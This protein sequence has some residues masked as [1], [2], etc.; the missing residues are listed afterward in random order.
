[1]HTKKI[2]LIT[3]LVIVGLGILLYFDLQKNKEESKIPKL[4]EEIALFI[5]KDDL[6]SV[7][8]REGDADKYAS[9]EVSII[10]KGLGTFDVTVT[11]E[12][13]YD[14][15]VKAMRT[16]ASISYKNESWVKSGV[17]KTQQCRPNRGHEDFSGERCI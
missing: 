8:R 5:L 4:T 13:L 9:C 12:G 15:S 1:M 17:E 10:K 3:I 14:D 2:I 6:F 11:Y 16:K 7:C